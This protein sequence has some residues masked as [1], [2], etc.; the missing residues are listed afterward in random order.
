MTTHTTTEPIY[1]EVVWGIEYNERQ[2]YAN[3]GDGSFLSETAEHRATGAWLNLNRQHV[4]AGFF[5]NG[6]H[7]AGHDFAEE[8]AAAEAEDAAGA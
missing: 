7:D 5:I 3:T 8:W 4:K 1:Y 2:T 6:V